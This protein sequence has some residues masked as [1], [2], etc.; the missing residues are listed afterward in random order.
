M[1]SVNVSST[2]TVL[3]LLLKVFPTV[4]G[5]LWHTSDGIIPLSVH[6]CSWKNTSCCKYA[7]YLHLATG[8]CAWR[9]H[10]CQK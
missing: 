2:D 8:F 6:C 3:P 5:I 9:V 4:L 10:C 7:G 1:G